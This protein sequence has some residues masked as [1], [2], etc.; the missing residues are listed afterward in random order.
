LKDKY[1]VLKKPQRN[2]TMD[3]S[4]AQKLM[5]PPQRQMTM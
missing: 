2:M 1:N 5:Q 4:Y 3:L